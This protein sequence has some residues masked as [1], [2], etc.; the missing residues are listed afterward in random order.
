M[1]SKDPEG[2]LDPL[3]DDFLRR[4][5]SHPSPLLRYKKRTAPSTNVWVLVNNNNLCVHSLQIVMVGPMDN[6]KKIHYNCFNDVVV[7]RE[8]AAFWCDYNH[9][10]RAL[11]Q[12]SE[13]IPFPHL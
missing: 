1:G 4:F 6:K 3:G 11:L 5:F 12:L 8:A 9:L 10:S 13:H 7:E 2:L